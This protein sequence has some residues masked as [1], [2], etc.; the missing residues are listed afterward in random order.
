M[1][2]LQSAMEQRSVRSECLVKKPLSMSE[3]ECKPRMSKDTSLNLDKLVTGDRSTELSQLS[4]LH[5]LRYNYVSAVRHC[6]KHRFRPGRILAD[7]K[8]YN[9][10]RETLGMA[11]AM[12]SM[13]FIHTDSTE[14]MST[15]LVALRAAGPCLISCC[16]TCMQLHVMRAT[17][18]PAPS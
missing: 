17:S 2:E 10:S 11:A 8:P 6:R 14:S 5:R 18:Q 3:L 9:L 1:L 15:A 13:L 12:Q 4:A 7:N 16:I